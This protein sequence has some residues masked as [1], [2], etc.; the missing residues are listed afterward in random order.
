MHKYC[1]AK[2]I[3]GL[4]LKDGKVQLFGRTGEQISHAGF[5]DEAG[6]RD[7]VRPFRRIY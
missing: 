5:R 2:A 3:S 6:R 7:P 4:L 1:P